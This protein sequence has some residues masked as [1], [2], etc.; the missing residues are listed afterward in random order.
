MGN[1][2]QIIN[3][4]IG[5]IQTATLRYRS[6]YTDQYGTNVVV[7]DGGENGNGKW[8]NYLA[9]IGELIKG[10]K[11]KDI[12][13]WVL[14]IENDA[15]DDTFTVHLGVKDLKQSDSMALKEKPLPMGWICP[16][17]GRSFS[18]LVRECPY[19]NNPTP[20]P[21]QPSPSILPNQP[22]PSTN[23]WEPPYEITCTEPFVSTE[24]GPIRWL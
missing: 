6:D 18:L 1:I 15:L 5:G 23:P 7:I 16:R 9:E 4:I 22:S 20:I 8:E 13:A 14:K 2:E 24:P 10:L 17:C 12:D 3:E 21:N 11:E 19:C